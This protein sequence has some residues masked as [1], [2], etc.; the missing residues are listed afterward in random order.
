VLE[1]LGAS[2]TISALPGKYCPGDFSLHLSDGPKIA[3]AAQRV[4]SGAALYTATILV[5]HGRV[6]RRAAG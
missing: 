2:C 4:I 6:G 1:P 5:E 3:G